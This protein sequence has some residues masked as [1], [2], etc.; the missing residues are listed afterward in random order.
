MVY[1]P[2]AHDIGSQGR[3][4]QLSADIQGFGPACEGVQ[5][6]GEGFPLPFDAFG[7]HRAWYIFHALHY[8]DPPPSSILAHR[9]KAYAT[10]AHDRCRHAMPGG[11]AEVRIPR[12]LAIVMS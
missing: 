6:F 1:G 2:I 10:V 3:M 4:R 7:Q 8:F 11:R 12:G 5:V 9:G